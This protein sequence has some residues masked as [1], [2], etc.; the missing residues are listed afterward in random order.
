[1]RREIKTEDPCSLLPTLITEAECTHT[2]NVPRDVFI[3]VRFGDQPT[4]SS[5]FEIPEWHND[6][7]TRFGKVLRTV[8]LADTINRVAEWLT[9]TPV[10][11][12]MPELTGYQYVAAQDWFFGEARR[13]RGT[14]LSVA[15]VVQLA[16]HLTWFFPI[17]GMDTMDQM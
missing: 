5:G 14:N 10:M 11:V 16:K 2:L 4:L 6:P 8:T 7:G 1:M 12:T 15:E 9:G 17:M 3:Q 13:E